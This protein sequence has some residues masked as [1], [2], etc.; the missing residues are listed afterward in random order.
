MFNHL[1]EDVAAERCGRLA[2]AVEQAD[3]ERDGADVELLGAHHADGFKDLLAGKV[4]V[5]HPRGR[6]F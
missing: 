6:P 3:A 2:H 4:E 1:V 5:S